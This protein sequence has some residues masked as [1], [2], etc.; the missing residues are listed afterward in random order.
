MN[1]KNIAEVRAKSVWCQDSE[2]HLFMPTVLEDVAF[3]P[4]NQD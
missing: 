3:G 4:L 1:L 2:S